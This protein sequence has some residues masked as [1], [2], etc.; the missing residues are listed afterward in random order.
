MLSRRAVRSFVA[1]AQT[2]AAV[3]RGGTAIEPPA[4]DAATDAQKAEYYIQVADWLDQLS[5]LLPEDQVCI[6]L[7]GLSVMWQSFAGM[8]A[9]DSSIPPAVLSGPGPAVLSDPGSEPLPH[10]HPLLQAEAGRQGGSAVHQCPTPPLAGKAG[11]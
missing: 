2:R 11:R 6:L 4:E 7:V 5:I 8:A 9:C 1:Y 3:Q 10:C